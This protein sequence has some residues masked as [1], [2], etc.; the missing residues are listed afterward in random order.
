M[1]SRR[2]PSGLLPALAIGLAGTVPLVV[3]HLDGPALQRLVDLAVYRDAGQSLLLDRPVYE[4]ESAQTELPFTYPPLAALLA[5][6]L[7]LVP[8]PLLDLVWT[9]GSLLVLA[10]LAR[11]L[12][13]S[14]RPVHFALL[15]VGLTWLLPVRETLRFGQVNLLL[16]GLVVADL[17]ARRPRWPRGALVGLAAAVKLTP[18]VLVPWLWLSGRRREAVWACV[19]A[20]GLTVLAALLLP[21][22]SEAFWTDA[23]L[24]PDR[25]GSNA[26]ISNQSLRGVLLRTPLPETAGTV[27]WLVAAGLVGVLGLRRA[28]RADLLPGLT[29]AGL[30]AVLLSPVAWQHHLVWVVPALAVLVRAGRPRAALATALY[31]TLTIPSFGYVQG[32]E[33][34][35][36]E[37]LWWLLEQS[38]C[39]GA[40]ALVAWLPLRLPR[41]EPD[42]PRSA[43]PDERRALDADSA[44]LRPAS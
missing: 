41:P 37:P 38:Y 3:G 31:F 22:T 36:G 32:K 33:G 14:L 5:V 12:F 43:Y 29:I 7:A 17:M 4:H 21:A 18:L 19:A 24:R 10:L 20:L 13:P 27:L 25:L 23:L 6:P 34:W 9:L 44:G 28:A 30:L 42:T 40:L 15:F 35:P 39:W 1:R 26:G 8:R 16:L 2:L 11:R